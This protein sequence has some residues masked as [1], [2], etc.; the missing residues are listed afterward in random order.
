[1]GNK[2]LQK[3]SR[4][5]GPQ[6]GSFNP[7]YDDRN[8]KHGVLSDFRAQ[9]LGPLIILRFHSPKA[10]HQA[11]ARL[12]AFYE[13]KDAVGTYISLAN[14]QT[15]RLCPNYKAFNLPT[16][17]IYDWL[18]AMRTAELGASQSIAGK[19][20]A[21]FQG[22]WGPFVNTEESRL[23]AHLAQ[24]GCFG[25]LSARGEVPSYLIS[26]SEQSAI[27]HEALHALYFLHSDYRDRAQEVWD[28]LS[29]RC[30]LTIQQGMVLRGYGSH[31]WVDEFQAYVS[32]NVGEFGNKTKEECTEVKKL[33]LS[34]Q[35]V[36]WK[37]LG[38]NISAIHQGP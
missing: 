24:A 1:M 4:A 13:S 16:S 15:R 28:R 23:L 10:Q 11:L 20:E 19:F 12:E 25:R 36:A 33:L 2:P 7:H 31:V 38:M 29:K 9:Q 22:W 30:Q 35:E 3:G 8:K 27:L 18:V 21:A 5:K 17:A 14:P 32:E 26:V 6:K 37:E 34:A